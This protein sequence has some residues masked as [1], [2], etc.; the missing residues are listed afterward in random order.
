MHTTTHPNH[1]KEDEMKY[2]VVNS[3]FHN[4]GILFETSSPRE[5]YRWR[6]AHHDG[7]F[8]G[9]GCESYAI[10]D[11]GGETWYRCDISRDTGEWASG[12][13]GYCDGWY[14]V[15][16]EIGAGAPLLSAYDTFSALDPAL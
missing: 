15:H 10:S 2:A 5:A 13:V 12:D 16:D 8:D 7:C 3:K 6:R 9:A 11:D 14:S 4:G 1:H